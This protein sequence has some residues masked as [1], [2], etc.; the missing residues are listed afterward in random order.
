VI[1]FNDGLPPDGRLKK[2]PGTLSMVRTLARWP[3]EP[4]RDCEAAPLQRLEVEVVHSAALR[5]HFRFRGVGDMARA[6]F[7]ALDTPSRRDDLWKHTCAE[8]FL[9]EPGGS[10][11]E[12]NFSPS[13]R[14]AAYRFASYRSGMK[15]QGLR[16]VPA[17]DFVTMPDS[18]AL[19]AVVDLTG[20]FA[21]PTASLRMGIAAVIEHMDGALSHWALAHP[22]GK[23]DFHHADSFVV[24]LPDNVS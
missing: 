4:H 19:D 1:C 9:M 17:I 10:Y 8:V 13:T 22:S 14:W 18:F 24:A 20:V 12:F 21:S 2:N 5:W 3:L 23:P 15:E 7:P 16:S 11:C 6:R